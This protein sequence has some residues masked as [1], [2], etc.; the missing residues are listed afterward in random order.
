MSGKIISPMDLS[1]EEIKFVFENTEE[2]YYFLRDGNFHFCISNTME[3]P[4]KWKDTPIERYIDEI[5]DELESSGSEFLYEKYQEIFSDEV[6]K[7]I[8]KSKG[9]KSMTGFHSYMDRIKV[10]FFHHIFRRVS[11]YIN[12]ILLEWK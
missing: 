9:A 3:L 8:D 11:G 1:K 7:A 6:K 2:L 10:Y 12:P 5:M 4:E